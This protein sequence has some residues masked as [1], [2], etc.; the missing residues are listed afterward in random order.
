M[1][2]FSDTTNLN[3]L[4][5]IF[6]RQTGL[7]NT[8]VSGNAN[9]LKIVTA[10]FNDSFDEIMP[11]LL[12]YSDHMRWDDLNHTDL[13][14]GTLNIVSGQ[15]DYSVA[16]DDNSLDILNIINVRIYTTSSG[17]EYET[18][19]RM[20]IDDERALDAMSP[21]PSNTGVPSHWLENNNVIFLYPEPNYSATNGVKIFFEREQD[22]FASTDTTA[23]PG[24]P[25]PFHNLLADIASHAWLTEYDSSKTT[26]I[27]RLEAKIDKRSKAL[28]RLIEPRNP[29]RKI[30]THRRIDYGVRGASDIRSI[31]FF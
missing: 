18:L 28:T 19:T 12:S 14:I 17:T 24:I 11:L 23:E 2:V 25:K 31:R 5:Q 10:L 21:N 3:G 20:T 6:E 26:L 27:T 30:M 29:T 15:A 16:V 22:Y 13:P 1:S 7:G 4:I 8:A 9:L